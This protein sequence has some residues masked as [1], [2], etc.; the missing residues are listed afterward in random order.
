[1]SVLGSSSSE[2]RLGPTPKKISYQKTRMSGLAS[3]EPVQ[4]RLLRLDHIF[5]AWPVWNANIA[6]LR[7]STSDFEQFATRTPDQRRPMFM[8]APVECVKELPIGAGVISFT[9]G[10]VRYVRIEWSEMK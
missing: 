7:V 9:T 6:M 10:H 3:M 1:M 8:R 5:N 4:R 2:T